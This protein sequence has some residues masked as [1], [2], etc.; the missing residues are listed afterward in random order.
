MHA[1]GTERE[2]VEEAIKSGIKTLGF[3]DHTPYFYDNGFVS[4]DKMLPSELEGYVKTVKDLAR[5]YKSDIN[6]Y[7]GLEAEYYPKH[8]DKLFKFI[9]ELGIEYL[10]LG[11]H[12]TLNEYDGVYAFTKSHTE[13]DFITYANQV[14]EGINRDCFSYIAHPDVFYYPTDTDTYREYMQKICLLAKQKNIPLEF[15]LAG[16]ISK[17]WYPSEDF[18][19][20]A[21]KVGNQIIFGIDAHQKFAFNIAQENYQRALNL[22]KNYGLEITDKI[23]LLDGTTV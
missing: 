2:Y 23:K 15:N 7:L 20:I 22:V 4:K 9:K 3:S 19:K 17:H 16:Y 12:Y 10:I 8:F 5:E 21:K 14:C 6:I 18:L 1:E 13:S 11:Q